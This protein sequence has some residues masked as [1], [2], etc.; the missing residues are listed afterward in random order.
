MGFRCESN[1]CLPCLVWKVNRTLDRIHLA[2]PTYLVTIHDVV[3]TQASRDRWRRVTRKWLA[4]YEEL[5]VYEPYATKVG[6]HNHAWVRTSCSVEVM[7]E[8][9][10][11]AA[12]ASSA[13]GAHVMRLEHHGGLDYGFKMLV[14]PSATEESRE[15]FFEVNGNR[16]YRASARLPLSS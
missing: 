8:V 13:S 4:G 10:D 1:W 14:S 5:S 16:L 9:A 11:A 3:P 12:R 7:E 2:D 6:V 15:A